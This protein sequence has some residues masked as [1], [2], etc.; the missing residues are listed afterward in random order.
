ML[1]RKHPLNRRVVTAEEYET[2]VKEH[3]NEFVDEEMAREVTD[4]EVIVAAGTVYTPEDETALEEWVRTHPVT[5]SERREQDQDRQAEERGKRAR[6]T[7]GPMNHTTR[8]LMPRRAREAFS[9]FE[10]WADPRGGFYCSTQKLATTITGRPTVDKKIGARLISLH[11]AA[12]VIRPDGKGKGTHPNWYRL[13]RDFD[14]VQATTVYRQHR[15]A[16]K[17]RLQALGFGPDNGGIE[18]YVS[19]P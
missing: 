3:I 6:P 7:K 17:T 19:Q 11:V 15:E 8:N 12:G 2:L 16:A 1:P 5:A 4:R 9:L 14:H 10:A 18:G 13:V